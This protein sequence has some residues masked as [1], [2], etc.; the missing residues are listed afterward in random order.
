MVT[1]PSDP[2]FLSTVPSQRTTFMTDTVILRTR[3]TADA[4]VLEFSI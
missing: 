1:L 2:S 3:E 4:A